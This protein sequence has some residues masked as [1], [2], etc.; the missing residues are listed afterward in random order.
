M[1]MQNVS[2]LEIP[3]GEVRTIHDKDSRLLWGRVHY[4]TK[5]KG[6]IFQQT[7]SGKNLLDNTNLDY[8][9]S[10]VGT[11]KNH[12]S[13]IDTGIRYTTTNPGGTPIVRWTTSLRA[14][15]YA[16]KTVRMRSNFGVGGGIRL[17]YSN[18]DGSSFTGVVSSNTSGEEITWTVPSSISVY[19]YVNFVLECEVSAATTVDYTNLILTIDEPT[20]PF[21]PYTNGPSPNPDYPQAINVVTGEQTVT[22]TGKNLFNKAITP[23]YM[24]SGMSVQQLPT[25][26]RAINDDIVISSTV[27]VAYFKVCDLSDV[28]GKTITVK[29]NMSASSTNNP[30]LICGFA[31]SNFG[32][33]EVKA[34][35]DASGSGSFVVE[36][37]QSNQTI[38]FLG[39]Y[40]TISRV[41]EDAPAGAYSDYTDLQ[42]EISN[43]PTDYEAFVDPITKTID[44]GSTELAKIGTYVD[45]IFKNDPTKSWYNPDLEDNAW[46]VHKE[47]GKIMLNGTEANFMYLNGVY[48]TNGVYGYFA[49][50]TILSNYYLAG[51]NAIATSTAYA[52]GN[53]KISLNMNDK[54]SF[55]LRNDNLT[56]VSDWETWLSNHNTIIYYA[57]ATPTDTKITDAMLIGQLNAIH[58]WLV[59]YGYYGTVSTSSPSILPMI[60][61]RTNL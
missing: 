43:T 54:R 34:Q 46:Y 53:N 39:L 20:T 61:D 60:I 14:R 52:N 59:R 13:T 10:N 50:A 36:G 42:V 6:D 29:A 38:I 12:L 11:D 28:M 41:G 55:Y 5:Y 31:R 19:Y 58:E 35:L 22:V 40:A 26:I 56:S 2:N 44:L 7:Y 8:T 48:Y 27:R 17:G 18:S 21:E 45:G 32:G 15:D 37:A 24:S 1:D 30:R 16:G 49:D 47:T 23:G 9:A 51:G 57:L 25:G 3:E 4:D 33:R